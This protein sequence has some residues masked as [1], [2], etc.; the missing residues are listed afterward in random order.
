M[1]TKQLEQKV[2]ELEKRV[3]LL[4]AQRPIVNVYP[5][6]QIQPAPMP[7]PQFPPITGPWCG[8][9]TTPNPT[10]LITS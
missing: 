5:G 2:G 8:I 1:T 4:E 10:P 7:Q 6:Y 3:L 9:T